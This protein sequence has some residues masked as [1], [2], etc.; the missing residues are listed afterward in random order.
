[1][2]GKIDEKLLVAL[3][4]QD[5]LEKGQQMSIE[6]ERWI[7]AHGIPDVEQIYSDFR[8]KQSPN[9]E[10]DYIKFDPKLED[11]DIVSYV[12]LSRAMKHGFNSPQM[13][14]ALYEC[15]RHGTSLS[16]MTKWTQKSL[17]WV[18]AR[19]LVDDDYQEFKELYS[20]EPSLLSENM[21]SF[22]KKKHKEGTPISVI[23]SWTNLSHRKLEQ[24]MASTAEYTA[25]VTYCVAMPAEV[26]AEDRYYMMVG[27][28]KP[29]LKISKTELKN[30]AREYMKDCGL[31]TQLK[32]KVNVKYDWTNNIELKIKPMGE[33]DDADK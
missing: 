7:Q 23:S 22:Y 26:S 17:T 16:L 29:D 5:Y 33:I 28:K 9:Y 27:K 21:K 18:K 6:A 3:E 14:E 31:S 11:N 8:K 20:R 25:E 24:V 19:A 4:Y 10:I 32:L 30:R 1:M 12:I 2:S 15:Y 13:D